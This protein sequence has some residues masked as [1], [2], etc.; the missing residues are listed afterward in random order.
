MA[1][2]Q[3][4]LRDLWR[5]CRRMR[6]WCPGV[7]IPVRHCPPFVTRIT[8]H[9]WVTLLTFRYCYYSPFVRAITH[10]S[11]VMALTPR[12]LTYSRQVS[13]FCLDGACVFA[14]VDGRKCKARQLDSAF[15]RRI[16]SHDAMPITS[17]IWRRDEIFCATPLAMYPLDKSIYDKDSFVYP[18]GKS[19]AA[20]QQKTPFSHQTFFHSLHAFPTEEHHRANVRKKDN[21]DFDKPFLIF[22]TD[23]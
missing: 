10:D 19:M 7:S 23:P 15:R 6:H 13:K 14:M 11:W 2:S 18:K 1:T 8:H 12:Y 17:R 20:G 22:Y 16:F 21:R 4:R 3:F 9:L 5:G